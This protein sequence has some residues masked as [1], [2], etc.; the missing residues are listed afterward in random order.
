VS[1]YPRM[2]ETARRLIAQYGQ[3]VT[4]NRYAPSVNGS[5]GVVTKGTATSTATA[6]AVSIPVSK[7]PSEAFGNKRESGSLAKKEIR[8]LQIEAVGCTFEPRPDD[9]VT[10]S[11]ATWLVLGCTPVNPAGTPLVYG[12]GLVKL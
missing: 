9:E 8:F 2:A 12:V 4:I 5:T 6:Y 7:A 3:A 10:M 1:L 11:S